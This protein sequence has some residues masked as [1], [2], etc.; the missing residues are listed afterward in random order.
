M[1]NLSYENEFCMQ[2]HSHANQNHFHNNSFALR[3]ALKQRHKGTRKWPIA[4]TC[5]SVWLGL[6]TTSVISLLSWP[7][8]LNIMLF[9][10][11]SL[12]RPIPDV[13]LL[14]Y[15]LYSL[16]SSSSALP[17]RTLPCVARRRLGTSQVVPRLFS[18]TSHST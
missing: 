11:F 16:L 5:R 2:F 6:K 18:D 17:P 4:T 8:V 13:V 15:K 14:P 3:L 12:A 9:L 7:L 1:R 10:E